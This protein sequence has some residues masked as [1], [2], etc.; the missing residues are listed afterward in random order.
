MKIGEK[1]RKLLAFVLVVAMLLPVSAGTLADDAF[2]EN[3]GIFN[4]DIYPEGAA[5]L[6]AENK[7]WVLEKD[8]KPA[9]SKEEGIPSA[10]DVKSCDGEEPSAIEVDG[11]VILE[12]TRPEEV[13]I[14]AVEAITSD[15]GSTA[16]VHITGDVVAG[17]TSTEEYASATAVYAESGAPSMKESEKDPVSNTTTV[18][19]DGKAVAKASA[20][21]YEPDEG[22]DAPE[23]GM[24][25]YAVEAVAYGT[26]N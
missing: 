22:D 10:L 14:T 25:T 26:A 1:T 2:T 24:T 13:Y 19:V 18:T 3:I 21:A 20:L 6:D 17:A 9:P 8:L 12:E 23:S 7:C 11:D 4:G 15:N 5:V 16:D